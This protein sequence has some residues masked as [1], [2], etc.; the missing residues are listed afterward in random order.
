MNNLG[1][2]LSGLIL[3]MNVICDL[4]GLRKEK[5]RKNG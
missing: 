4:I 3:L 5:R 2:L 1:D